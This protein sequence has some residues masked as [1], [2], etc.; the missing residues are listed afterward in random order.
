MQR[1]FILAELFV[2]IL[3]VGVLNNLLFL[4]VRSID[5]KVKKETCNNKR[6]PVIRA[7]ETNRLPDGLSKEA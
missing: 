7:L 1:G 3:I 5:Y 4:A 2:V 6:A